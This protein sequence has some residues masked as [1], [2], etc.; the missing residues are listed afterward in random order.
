MGNT[1]TIEIWR[2]DEANVTYKYVRYWGGENE[3]EAFKKLREVKKEHPEK[4][5]QFTWR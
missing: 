3:E 5:I 1:F 4:P 2:K